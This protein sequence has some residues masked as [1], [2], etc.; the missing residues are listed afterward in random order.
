VSTSSIAAS[1]LSLSIMA[2]PPVVH[3][4]ILQRVGVV[5][6]G[7]SRRAARMP[8]ANGTPLLHAKSK[9]SVL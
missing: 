7:N 3:Y 2:P 6:P 4:S 5:Q 1:L 9:Q 8:R